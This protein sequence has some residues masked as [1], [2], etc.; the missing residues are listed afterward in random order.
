MFC[1]VPFSNYSTFK[2][3]K[4]MISVASPEVHKRNAPMTEPT[5]SELTHPSR[6]SA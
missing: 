1:H 3:A 5:D 2:T 6:L 4:A